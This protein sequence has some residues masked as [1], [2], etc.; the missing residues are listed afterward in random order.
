M[1]MP[2]YGIGIVGIMEVWKHQD[3]Y[4]TSILCVTSGLEY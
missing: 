3:W 1:L 4:V 2:A